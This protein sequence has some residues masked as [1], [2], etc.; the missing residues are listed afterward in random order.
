[1]WAEFF[2]AVISLIVSS[3]LQTLLAPKPKKP[4]AGKLDVTVAAE[5]EDIEI[6]FGTELFKNTKVVWYGDAYTTPIKSKGG[7][8]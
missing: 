5:G 2:V 1:M 4:E 8:K 7:K 6:L 3:A